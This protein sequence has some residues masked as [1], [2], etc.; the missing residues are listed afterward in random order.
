MVPDIGN[1]PAYV[2]LLLGTHNAEKLH[3]ET[4]SK[5]SHHERLEK[6]LAIDAD[7]LPDLASGC[8]HHRCFVLSLF[9]IPRSA[10]RIPD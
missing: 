3:R 8:P 10:F 7:I 9:R 4:R 5:R 2:P 6:S 1:T